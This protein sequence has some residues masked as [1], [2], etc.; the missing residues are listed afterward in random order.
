MINHALRGASELH[1]R[2]VCLPCLLRISGLFYQSQCRSY[3][4]AAPPTSAELGPV[5]G[6]DGDG[7]RLL[8]GPAAFRR[9]RSV[10]N[11][12]TAPQKLKIRPAPK[13]SSGGSSTGDSKGTLEAQRKA[14]RTKVAAAGVAGHRRLRGG[15]SEPTYAVESRVSGGR[16]KKTRQK[17]PSTKKFISTSQEATEEGVPFSSDLPYNSTIKEALSGKTKPSL[18]RKG[19]SPKDVRVIDPSTLDI[20]REFDCLY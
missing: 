12:P 8:K 1:G 18:T 15:V 20:Q 5:D 11:S 16:V 13:A 9:V 2:S 14:S 17:E 3:V 6:G 10:R 7:A 19:T 4:V